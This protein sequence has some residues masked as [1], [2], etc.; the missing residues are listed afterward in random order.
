MKALLVLYSKLLEK[1]NFFE[2]L[3]RDIN[4]LK[5]LIGPDSLY[6]V[7]TSEMKE[8]FDRFPEL[9]FLRNDK[10]TLLYGIYKGL[11]KLRGN[12]V[13]ILDPKEEITKEKI[14]SFVSQRRKNVVSKGIALLKLIDLDYIIRTM[15]ALIDKELEFSQVMNL[16]QEEYGIDYEAL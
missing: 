1:E 5:K 6:A 12:D 7:I 3:E 9:V 13:L 15:E 2:K 16:V 10:D 14:L 11:R 8:L 4:L